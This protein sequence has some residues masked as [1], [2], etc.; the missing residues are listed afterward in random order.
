MPDNTCKAFPNGIPPDIL[1]GT[2]DHHVP[3]K[4]DN[5]IQYEKRMFKKPKDIPP[6]GMHS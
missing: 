4:G 5:G 3:H 6:E 1:F 2:V